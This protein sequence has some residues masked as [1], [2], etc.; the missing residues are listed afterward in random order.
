YYEF[1][2]F[3]WTFALMMVKKKQWAMRSKAWLEIEGNPVIGE[4]RMVMLQAIDYHG[5]FIQASKE[6]GISCRK[7]RGAVRDME[8]AVGKP[9]VK[10]YRGGGDG[11]GTTLTPTAHKLIEFFKQFTNG[12]QKQADICF[13]EIINKDL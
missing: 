8:K 12:F 11:G 13:K 7:I 10:A 3:V 1:S 5:S 2:V 6:I 4:G 9:L